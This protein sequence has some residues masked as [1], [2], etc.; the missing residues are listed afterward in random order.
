MDE[1][2]GGAGAHDANVGVDGDNDHANGATARRRS[3]RRRL[4][5]VHFNDVYNVEAQ[6]QAGGAPVGGAP[7]FVAECRRLAREE[8][9]LVLFSGD[10]YNPSLMSAT[11]TM[12]RQMPPVLNAC[13]VAAA[14][15][16][17]HD[18]D[19]GVGNFEALARDCSFPWLQANVLSRDT[20]EPLGGAARSIVIEHAGVR[21]GVMGL[22]EA[23]W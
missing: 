21:V 10:A 1:P 16:G 3:R 15:V 12:G 19:F 5:I 6:Q 11:V 8:G 2:S 4:A 23:D 17:N 13:G 9:A 14:C 20:G 7:R 18:L 22:A